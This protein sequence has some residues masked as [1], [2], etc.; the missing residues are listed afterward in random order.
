MS[1]CTVRFPSDVLRVPGKHFGI[2]SASNLY[3][4]PPGPAEKK[5]KKKGGG[6]GVEGVMVDGGR[7]EDGGEEGGGREVGEGGI[8]TAGNDLWADGRKRPGW[9]SHQL[10]NAA[11]I[12]GDRY[13][14]YEGIAT[15]RRGHRGGQNGRCRKETITCAALPALAIHCCQ[16]NNPP[17]L[18]NKKKTK[19]KTQQT[20]P[21][22]KK[23][24]QA[25][26]K[27]TT[28][29]TTTTTTNR[30]VLGRCESARVCVVSCV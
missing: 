18:Q 9:N 8:K 17:S 19:K 7:R 1:V 25:P 4:G 24:N 29:T 3:T 5:R 27:T 2:F 15:Q 16:E 26:P 10:F 28:T 11:C 21:P 13:T 12:L 6:G 22:K 23:Q 30:W 14:H 20:P